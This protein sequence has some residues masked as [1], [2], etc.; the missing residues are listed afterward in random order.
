[1]ATCSTTSWRARLHRSTSKPFTRASSHT[2]EAGNRSFGR[3]QN[4]QKMTG[5]HDMR[6]LAGEKGVTRERMT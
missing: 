3:D 1:M 5:N 4:D 6:M 2:T